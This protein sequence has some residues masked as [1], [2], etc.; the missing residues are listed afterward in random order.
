VKI[1][2]DVKGT[3][4]GPKQKQ[5]LAMLRAFH[6]MGHE[7]FV[8]SN[9]Y[10]YA[11]GAVMDHNLPALPMDKRMKMDYEAHE[12]M[13]LAIEDDRSQTWLAARRFVWVDEIPTDE[14]ALKDFIVAVLT[15]IP[16]V[17]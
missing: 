16:E 10:A 13:D 12:L 5:V 6:E 15:P 3:I 8:W 2:F 4:E 9:A 11:T 1:A 7:V 14:S 17:A